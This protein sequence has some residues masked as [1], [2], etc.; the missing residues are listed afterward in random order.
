MTFGFCSFLLFCTASICQS[1]NVDISTF[2]VALKPSVVGCDLY[3]AR[4][5]VAGSNPVSP[6]KTVGNKG[7]SDGLKNPFP[8]FRYK[9]DD[10]G[11]SSWHFV[12]FA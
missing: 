11:N 4:Q 2:L 3:S 5:N 6:T 1:K 9:H 12:I 10:R 7:V 8:G